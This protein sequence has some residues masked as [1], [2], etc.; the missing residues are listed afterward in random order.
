MTVESALAE[1]RTAPK[2][3]AL[4]RI[5]LGV[6]VSMVAVESIGLQS[7]LAGGQLRVPAFRGWVLP[8]DVILG[9]LLLSALAGLCIAI[10]VGVQPWCGAV[11]VVEVLLLLQDQQF[12]S[13]HRFLLMLLV[14]A[15]FF[16][17]SD[18]AYSP[19][20]RHRGNTEVPWWPQFLMLCAVSSCYLFAGLSKIN[21]YWWAGT[22][23]DKMRWVTLSDNQLHFVAALTIVTEVSIALGLW[24][25]RTRWL[26]IAAGIGLHLSIIVLLNSPFVFTA[27]ALLCFSVYPL[28]LTRPPLHLRPKASSDRRIARLGAKPT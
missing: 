23:I 27:F 15:L 3:V 24:W 5:L 17:R 19:A 14:G 28:A 18:A 22:Q 26:A 12:Y 20:A 7:R 9:L 8:D 13:N 16:A 2:P 1:L 21:P 4:T 11:L 6:A 25:R 10:G